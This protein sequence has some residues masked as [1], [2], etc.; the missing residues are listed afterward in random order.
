M[1]FDELF[2]YYVGQG[3]TKPINPINTLSAINSTQPEGIETVTPINTIGGGEGRDD[4]NN[5]PTTT[6]T[7]GSIK[8][9]FNQYQNLS[10]V[11]KLGVT[12]LANMVL[13]GVG[14]I[15]GLAGLGGNAANSGMLSGLNTTAFGNFTGG[16]FG[17]PQG[18]DQFGNNLNVGDVEVD[19]PTNIQ[20]VN[21]NDYSGGYGGGS[22]HDGGA[23]AS[24]QSDDAAGMGGYAAGGIVELLRNRYA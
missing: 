20:A 11:K 14:T 6:G 21:N 3:F 18:T 12:S 15:L 22:D 17:S 9:L 5:T 13:P 23:S 10:A 19:M 1:T 16:L 7:T 2:K 8:D 24:A 4:V